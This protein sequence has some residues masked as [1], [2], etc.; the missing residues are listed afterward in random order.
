MQEYSTHYRKEHYESSELKD[1]TKDNSFKVM[2]IINLAWGMPI[3][4]LFFLFSFFPFIPHLKYGFGME[5]PSSFSDY[6][7]IVGKGIF[8]GLVFIIVITT[9][10]TLIDYIRI[11]I[12]VML[13]YKKVGSFKV[14]KIKDLETSKVL[15][16]S[17]G[18]KL[19]IDDSE[20]CF[21]RIKEEDIVEIQKTATNKLIKI[22]I[23]SP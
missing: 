22:S 8:A 2:L 17:G 3:F 10:T 13:N 20:Y 15:Y 23:V 7:D 14:S 18:K 9:L 11:K 6:I 4:L 19:K 21:K 16:M 1:L 5:N 12:D